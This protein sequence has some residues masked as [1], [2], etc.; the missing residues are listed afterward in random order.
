MSEL[1]DVVIVGGGP[2]GC[3]TAIALRNLGVERVLIAESS[4]Y[5]K[6]RIGESIPPNSRDLFKRLGLWQAFDAED[7][8][9]CLGSCSS[10][11][12]DALGYNDFLFNLRGHGW[13]L[14]RL[15][16]DRF[17]ATEA[18][19]R[20]VFIHR[21]THFR[22]LQPGNA[23]RPIQVQFN[24]S[25]HIACRF[26]VDATGRMAKVARCLGAGR[27]VEDTLVCV[28]KY[29]DAGPNGA[30]GHLTRLEAVKY[31]WWYTAKL[32]GDR[33]I[34]VMASDLNL[35]RSMG[36]QNPLKWQQALSETRH[37]APVLINH[38]QSQQAL[39][40]WVAPS[41]ILNPPAGAGWLAVGDA[42]SAFDPISSQGIYKALADG[43]VAADSIVSW[44]QGNSQVL[45]EYRQYILERHIEY[46]RQRDY[47]YSLEQRWPDAPFWQKRQLMM[48]VSLVSQETEHC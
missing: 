43:L 39:Q 16:F 11:G 10:W 23:R 40:T 25:D 29:F 24:G 14:D 20:G 37:L 44:L 3:A 41:V 8:E 42:A 5:T 19:A 21:S 27:K 4:E 47:L 31:G 34:V 26:V 7:H 15:R 48:P 1:F 36:L 18:Q 22:A 38:H 12:A 13:H 46:L 32:P 30:L 2:A 45:A 35:I 28:G 9:I 17:M 6:P 33:I